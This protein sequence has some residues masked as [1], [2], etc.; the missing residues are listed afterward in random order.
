M[1]AGN[2][3]S[4]DFKVDD[5]DSED[6]DSIPLD[7]CQNNSRLPRTIDDILDHSS[8]SDHDE[9]ED[10]D[11]WTAGVLAGMAP[12]QR[13][14]R[15]QDQQLKDTPRRTKAKKIK[16]TRNKS[17][18]D[19]PEWTR[20]WPKPK[21][22]ESVHVWICTACLLF[23]NNQVPA[24]QRDAGLIQMKID[25]LSIL[26]P[27]TRDPDVEARRTKCAS[28]TREKFC[29]PI[30]KSTSEGLLSSALSAHGDVDMA[31]DDHDLD[32]LTPSE[33]DE[34]EAEMRRLQ[35]GNSHLVIQLQS[36]GFDIMSVDF[37]GD[38]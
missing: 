34:I 27:F 15:P 31:E 16:L 3:S 25:Q 9:A 13:M 32:D 36:F 2:V 30:V 12:L 14:S 1:D 8:N 35:R 6:L 38:E 29:L 23:L 21:L 5:F 26:P 4:D 10:L 7:A 19:N 28:C 33:L 24:K 11:S 20:P 17:S 37:M 22:Q 18:G